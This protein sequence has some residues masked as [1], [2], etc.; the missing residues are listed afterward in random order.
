[1]GSFRLQAFRGLRV[2]G[3]AALG[4][5]VFRV[6]SFRLVGCSSF[7]FLGGGGGLKAADLKGLSKIILQ[8]PFCNGSYRLQPTF[9]NPSEKT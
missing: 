5:G 6:W 4:F 8:G 7:F 2:Y 3:F 9:A 1:M